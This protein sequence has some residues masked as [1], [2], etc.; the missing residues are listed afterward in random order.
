MSNSELSDQYSSFRP[1]KE[2][3]AER[4]AFVDRLGKYGAP[5]FVLLNLA[6]ASMAV[7]GQVGENVSLTLW[8]SAVITGDANSN[9]SNSVEGNYT[10]DPYFVLSFSSITFVILFGALALVSA[11]TNPKEFVKSLQFPQWQFMLFGF[12]NVMNGLLAVYASPDNRTAPFLQ[13]I[14]SNI[15][16]PCTMLFR[17]EESAQS[18][19]DDCVIVSS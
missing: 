13:A 5:V 1:I 12:F 10:M 8:T 3:A 17:Y 6:F 7:L 11:A 19:T 15:I 14:L 16:I 9:C 2:K 18:E 4:P